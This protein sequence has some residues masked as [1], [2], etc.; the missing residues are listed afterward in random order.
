[1]T[2]PEDAPTGTCCPAC[3]NPDGT[4]GDGYVRREVGTSYVSSPCTLCMGHGHVPMMI[5]HAWNIRNRP[6]R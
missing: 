4:P 2:I 1:M 5:A 6:N 3:E